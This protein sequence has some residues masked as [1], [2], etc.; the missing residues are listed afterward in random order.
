MVIHVFPVKDQ[1]P[2]EVSG[3]VRSIMVKETEVVYITQSHLHF[4]DTEHLDTDLMYVITHPCF[5]LGN[6][7]YAY[8][9]PT[10]YS[11]DVYIYILLRIWVL[12]CSFYFSN[13]CRLSDAGR[14]FY[15]DTTNSMKKDAMVPVLKSFT[16]V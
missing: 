13:S 6:T 2:E 15:T 11:N 5:R 8:V 10:Y 16:Q 1:L 4:R 7:R 9:F 12:S 14:L 3:T